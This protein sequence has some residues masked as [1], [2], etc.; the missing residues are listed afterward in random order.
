[1]LSENFAGGDVFGPCIGQRWLVS[2]QFDLS[3]VTALIHSVIPNG[4][5]VERS[6]KFELV[7]NPRQR[8][9]SV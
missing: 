1:M 3:R 4:S 5:P 2:T 6:Q 9:R 8:N 7:I